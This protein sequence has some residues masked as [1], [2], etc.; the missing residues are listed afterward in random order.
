MSIY[1]SERADS[2]FFTFEALHRLLIRWWQLHHRKKRNPAGA[3]RAV[4]YDP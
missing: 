4:G 3:K 2:Q 1:A